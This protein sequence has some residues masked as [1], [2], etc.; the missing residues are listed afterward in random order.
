ME[1]EEYFEQI[2]LLDNLKQN[3]L[4]TIVVDDSSYGKKLFKKKR[5]KTEPSTKKSGKPNAHE[6]SHFSGKPKYG[7][8]FCVLYKQFGSAEETHNTKDCKRHKV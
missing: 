2:K 6:K 5:G 3:G 7:N 8:K 4:E 1:L